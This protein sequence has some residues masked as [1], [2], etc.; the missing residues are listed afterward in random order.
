MGMKPCAKFYQNRPTFIE[1]LQ[2]KHF[3]LFFPGH[4]VDIWHSTGDEI[5]FTTQGEDELYGNQVIPRPGYMATSANMAWIDVDNP[6]PAG[7]IKRFYIYVHNVTTP[8][9]SQ[10]RRI[11]LQVWRQVDVTLKTFRLTWSSLI[12]VSHL[13]ALYAVGGRQFSR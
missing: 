1:D 10:H 11:R 5:T 9:D 6:L 13:G 8:L 7:V 2:K 12:Q 3:V 4:S